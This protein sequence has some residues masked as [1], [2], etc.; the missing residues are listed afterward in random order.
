VI[1]STRLHFLLLILVILIF[2]SLQLSSCNSDNA[3]DPFQTEDNNDSSL[4][5]SISNQDNNPL[6]PKS[7]YI[8][9][10]IVLF[11]ISIGSVLVTIRVLFWRRD[12]SNGME[13]V[14]PTVLLENWSNLNNSV[15]LT[16]QEVQSLF[17]LLGRKI[18][19]FEEQISNINALTNSLSKANDQ[20]EKEIN[21]LRIGYETIAVRKF[22][23]KMVKVFSAFEEEIDEIIQNEDSKKQFNGLL[24]IFKDALVDAG[25]EQFTPETG[26]SYQSEFGILPNPLFVETSNP[27]LHLK[28]ES[29]IIPGYKLATT[30]GYEC[31]IPAKVR[32]YKYNKNRGE[33][34]G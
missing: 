29:V 15:Q 11:F 5:D 25:V 20:K 30:N 23:F 3:I 18:S 31:L 33:L 8:W 1:K 16:N 24:E 7:A 14:V 26:N 32:V 17:K 27:D 19:D 10:I 9:I 22:L 12:I 4:V 2:S 21:R 13:A 34:D 6:N 28:I